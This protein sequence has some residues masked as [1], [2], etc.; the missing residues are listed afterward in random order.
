MQ[1]PYLRVPLHLTRLRPAYRQALNGR[2]TAR[3]ASSSFGKTLQIFI[4]TR[5]HSRQVE[6]MRIFRRRT[7]AWERRAKPHPAGIGGY[8]PLSGFA[9]AVGSESHWF[10][11]QTLRGV[12]WARTQPPP[13]L[14][15]R[16]PLAAA[17]G[18]RYLLG[19][20]RPKSSWDRRA[21]TQPERML[22]C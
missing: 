12:H 6:G 2:C 9:L 18:G 22:V 19:L 20:S 8:H 7:L 13:V 1:T 5:S 3:E 16:P 10:S 21:A 4:L 17:K 11:P 14:H 15:L